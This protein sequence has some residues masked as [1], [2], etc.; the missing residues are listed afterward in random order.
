MEE[1]NL[2][3]DTQYIPEDVTVLDVDT[4]DPVPSRVIETFDV[5]TETPKAA[6]TRENF[7]GLIPNQD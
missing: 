7:P 5:N 2:D 4:Q 1:D 3:I 6:I